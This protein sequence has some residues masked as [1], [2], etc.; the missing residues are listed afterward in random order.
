[1]ANRAYLYA[2]ETYETGGW[3]DWYNRNSQ[4]VPYGDSRHTLPFAWL[5]FYTPRD[6]RIH[7]EGTWKVVRLIAPKAEAIAR[8]EARLPLLSRI[9]E[10][11]DDSDNNVADLLAVVRSWGGEYLSLDA[12]MVVDTLDELAVPL[13]ESLLRSLDEYPPDIA[14]IVKN[15]SDLNSI[16]DRAAYR[17]TRAETFR[18]NL[19]GAWYAGHA[20]GTS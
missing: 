14:R 17:E 8:F 15:A 12:D 16:L 3:H 19:V 6:I 13:F 2:T 7:D 4:T 18:N 9:T 20:P 1:M 11:R 10:S 5:F